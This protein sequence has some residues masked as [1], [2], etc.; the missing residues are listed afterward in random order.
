M[1]TISSLIV[2]TWFI[3]AKMA[4]LPDAEIRVKLRA[5]AKEIEVYQKNQGDDPLES[6]EDWV[7][8]MLS[9]YSEYYK[10]GAV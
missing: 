10:E 1:L 6:G 7:E 8:A 2:P 9:L 5:Y 4:G 3:E